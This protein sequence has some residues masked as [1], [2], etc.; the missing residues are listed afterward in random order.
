MAVTN[1]LL[2]VRFKKV[3]LTDAIL[4][5]EPSI[6]LP[7]QF[8]FSF[9]KLILESGRP[10]DQ[11]LDYVSKLTFPVFAISKEWTEPS[12]E[13]E[14]ESVCLTEFLLSTSDGSFC[15]VDASLV[16]RVPPAPKPITNHSSITRM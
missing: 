12:E 8:H 10:T 7:E 11:S 5:K 15:W 6:I 3:E 9:S 4:S 16:E 13:S 2:F 14:E 1:N